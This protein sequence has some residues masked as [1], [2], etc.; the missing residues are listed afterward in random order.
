VSDYFSGIIRQESNQ[1]DIDVP[2]KFISTLVLEGKLLDPIS[3][4]P[5][6]YKFNMSDNS[7]N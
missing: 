7:L 4:Y 6:R 3:S 5:P 2:R 1:N